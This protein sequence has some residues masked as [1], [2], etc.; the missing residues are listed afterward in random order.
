[1]GVKEREGGGWESFRA[2]RLWV[3]V[4]SEGD[5]E[6]ITEGVRHQWNSKG[7]FSK[8][9]RVLSTKSWSWGVLCF[10]E[11]ACL[12]IPTSSVMGRGQFL[13]MATLWRSKGARFHVGPQF[14]FLVSGKQVCS[15]SSVTGCSWLWTR[16][17]CSEDLITQNWPRIFRNLKWLPHENILKYRVPWLF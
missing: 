3:S 5:R 10:Q 9:D 4:T 15:V 11:L 12:C 2:K 13:S 1:M 7:S 16:V 8:A 14:S 17:V 6:G